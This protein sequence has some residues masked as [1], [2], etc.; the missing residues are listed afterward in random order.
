MNARLATTRTRA[1]LRAT[2]ALGWIVL[3][4]CEG[5]SS[6]EPREPDMHQPSRPHQPVP[7]EG[8]SDASTPAPQADASIRACGPTGE[9]DLRSVGEC[10]SGQGCVLFRAEQR[11]GDSDA[12]ADDLDAGVDPELEESPSAAPMCLPV[13]AVRDGEPCAGPGDCAEGLDCSAATGGTCRR[14][15]CDLNA[16][17]GCPSAQFCRVELRDARDQPTGVAL[18]DACDGCDL[19]GDDCPAMQACYP[20]AAASAACNACLPVGARE[21]GASCDFSNQCASG[22]ACVAIAGAR[23]CVQ[24]CELGTETCPEDAACARAQG[25]PFGGGVGLCSAGS[26]TH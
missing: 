1:W 9:C 21:P 7:N 5:A 24:L 22:A 15:C 23:S 19:L 2:C 26:S 13:G 10:E 20:L 14:Y 17:G 11:A 16:T 12:G 8:R 18:C 3:A 6:S 4:A 25:D